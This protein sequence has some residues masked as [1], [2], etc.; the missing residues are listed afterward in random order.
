MG[1]TRWPI[2]TARGDA[3]MRHPGGGEYPEGNYLGEYLTGYAQ[4]G[5]QPSTDGS[6]SSTDGP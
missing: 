2:C 1:Q 6:D 4:R 3:G 5:Y